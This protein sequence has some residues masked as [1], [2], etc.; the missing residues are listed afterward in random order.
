M[1]TTGDV[2]LAVAPEI[3]AAIAAAADTVDVEA[4]VVDLAG[5]T[6]LD[7]SGI[8]A[9]LRGRRLADQHHLDYLC[10]RCTGTGHDGPGD[11]GGLATPVRPRLIDGVLSATHRARFPAIQP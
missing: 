1:A 10:R 5:V 11:D 3:D 7:S 8:N 9:L 2:D 6:F 4:I